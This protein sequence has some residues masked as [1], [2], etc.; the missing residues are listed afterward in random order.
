MTHTYR[1]FSKAS[2]WVLGIKHLA[3]LHLKIQTPKHGVLQCFKI[4][5]TQLNICRH[6]LGTSRTF[7]LLQKRYDVTLLKSWHKVKQLNC[8]ETVFIS[9]KKYFKRN[10]DGET[11]VF[12]ATV[13]MTFTAGKLHSSFVLE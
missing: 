8:K 5:K 13:K 3:Y 12:T 10:L 7:L 2:L 1:C 6:L 11:D 9:N 4:M